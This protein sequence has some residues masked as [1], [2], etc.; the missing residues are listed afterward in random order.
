MA[1]YSVLL[2]TARQPRAAEQANYI[3]PANRGFGPKHCPF[4]TTGLCA[5]VHVFQSLIMDTKSFPDFKLLPY[6]PNCSSLDEKPTWPIENPISL[7]RSSSWT[8]CGPL[9]NLDPNTLPLSFQTWNDN[10]INGS[11]L[12][13]LLTFLGFAHDILALNAISHYWVTIRA[14]TGS[15]EFD[16]PRWHTDDL[17]FSPRPPRNK[18]H[19]RHSSIR[20]AIT[21]ARRATTTHVKKKSRDAPSLDE[22]PLLPAQITTT[23]SNPTNWKL[24]TTLLGPGTLF[25]GPET[26]AVARHVQRNVKRTVREENSSH[27][28]ASVRC[29]GCATASESVRARLA[30][31]LAR[32]GIVQARHGECVF[33][34]VG[35]EEG[36]VHSEPSSHG[37]RI[38][39]N[40]VPGTEAD[41]RNLMAK[42][43]MEYPRAW[44]VGLP[45]RVWD[46]VSGRHVG[47]L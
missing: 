31:E 42:W 25:I 29:A 47:G 22:P 3:C 5:G 21:Q 6:K 11:L 2:L 26:G 45:L 36:A 24:T 7:K 46:E 8:Y 40:I 14:S 28:C 33:F 18:G 30:V 34:R 32:H 43:G 35:E 10:T 38:F 23:S 15:S 12:P 4:G 13:S 37:D 17:F 27:I 1:A 41:L 20:N 39:V 9:L 16:I 44:S 19:R